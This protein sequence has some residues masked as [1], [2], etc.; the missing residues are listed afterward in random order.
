MTLTRQT[1]T[2]GQQASANRAA[3]RSRHHLLEPHT[4]REAAIRLLPWLKTIFGE[5][6][7]MI[8]VTFGARPGNPTF[9]PNNRQGHICLVK[10]AI[11]EQRMGK[12][13][14]L[15]G[16]LWD[17]DEGPGVQGLS[18]ANYTVICFPTVWQD[19]DSPSAMNKDVYR[20]LTSKGYSVVLSGS[21]DAKD[22][23][24]FHWRGLLDEPIYDV[25]EF[26]LL[27][28]GIKDVLRADAS[29]AAPAAW[30]RVP[31]M[32]SFPKEKRPTKA[33]VA[34]RD[35]DDHERWTIEDLRALIPSDP[36]RERA[37][38]A[39]R[40]SEGTVTGIE[41]DPESVLAGDLV[42]ALS[43]WRNPSGRD[44]SEGCNAIIR[45][46][47]KAGMSLNL[48]AG[49]MSEHPHAHEVADHYKGPKHLMGDV[50]EV[51]R[52]AA[53]EALPFG[54]VVDDGE[55]WSRRPELKH[56]HDTARARGRSPWGYFG[57]VYA[58]T[59]CIIPPRVVLPDLTGAYGSLNCLVA[60]TGLPSAGK[61]ATVDGAT[62]CIQFKQ[63]ITTLPPGTGEGI[64]KQYARR[65]KD[66][67]LDCIRES[68]LT[69]VDEI[70][71][72]R[73]LFSRVG[74]SLMP[75]L[76]TMFSGGTLG[77]T[78][79][80]D[81]KSVPI[82]SHRYRNAFLVGVQPE[83]SDVIFDHSGSGFPQRFLWFPVKEKGRKRDR[84]LVKPDP[85]EYEARDE[86]SINLNVTDLDKQRPESE[87][88]V[89]TLPEEAV[90]AIIDA[91]DADEDE[92]LDGHALFMRAKVAAVLMWL[93][94]R[95]HDVS[96]EDWELAGTVM[97][98]STA[99]RESVRKQYA[100]AKEKQRHT[101]E[102]AKG[103]GTARS[104]VARDDALLQS[105]IK[106]YREV[107]E[108]MSLRGMGG[109]GFKRKLGGGDRA[110][111]HDAAL[112]FL[113]VE[114]KELVRRKVKVNGQDGYKYFRPGTE[115]GVMG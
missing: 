9:Y 94:G 100:K 81:A 25:A 97:A 26:R 24:A 46:C 2:V 55:F 61:S 5:T 1:H 4:L 7:G 71:Q 79:A 53:E 65:G 66:G 98:M 19:V 60:L 47:Y 112:D 40:R 85:F 70:N 17:T 11:R 87:F 31:E 95:R 80:D 76:L 48:A 56:I 109:A 35:L 111:F 58:R 102:T 3:R 29:P 10:Q 91:D 27:N 39:V 41:Y 52:K 42:K 38:G 43:F 101:V 114:A 16:A 77:F 86:D 115:P 64:S 20:R 32:V 105:T 92:G 34:Q 15:N 37:T 67:Q 23:P 108:T 75:Q 90:D 59:A 63:P 72:I 89:L 73:A 36:V 83:N 99:T 93:N 18:L 51:Y 8:A 44:R 69:H 22:R 21:H 33:W 49:I 68:F 62:R 57:V 82:A 113:V 6:E 50:A 106:R 13:A 110:K 107:I 104:D 84:S 96:S 103:N 45:E 28:S 30:L 78:N 88:H 12:N 54:D 74:A 14:Y